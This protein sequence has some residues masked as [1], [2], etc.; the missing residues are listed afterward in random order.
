ME[1]TCLRVSSCRGLDSTFVL[2]CSPLESETVNMSA[3]A[4]AGKVFVSGLPTL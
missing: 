1:Q 4:A 3:L 2:F